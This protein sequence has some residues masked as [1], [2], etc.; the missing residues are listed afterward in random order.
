MLV[1]TEFT[2]LPVEA[3]RSDR[4]AEVPP[5]L[6][7]LVVEAV[8]VVVL[9]LPVPVLVL[10]VLAVDVL[11]LVELLPVEEVLAEDAVLADPVGV[12]VSRAGT[13]TSFSASGLLM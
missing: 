4:L 9:V 2:A 10:A 3:S 1:A 8:L 11:G 13:Y 12:P 7:L 6:V 5:L